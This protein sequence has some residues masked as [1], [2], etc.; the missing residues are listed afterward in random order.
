LVLV[1]RDQVDLAI[2]SMLE[3][4]PDFAYESFFQFDPM[5]IA[6]ARPPRAD[7]VDISLEDLSPYGLVLPPKCLSTWGQTGTSVELQARTAR[8]V[9]VPVH[10]VQRSPER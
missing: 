3:V 10:P 8:M 4:P 5:L 9:G 1:L 6:P 2:G 7:R